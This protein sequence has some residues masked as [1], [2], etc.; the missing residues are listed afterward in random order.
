MSERK[1]ILRQLGKYG[2]GDMQKRIELSEEDQKI[3]QYIYDQT[4]GFRKWN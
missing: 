4:E 1:S 2:S 3:L